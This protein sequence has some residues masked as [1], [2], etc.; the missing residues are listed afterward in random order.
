MF[1]E[2]SCTD[3]EIFIVIYGSEE[4]GKQRQTS[5]LRYVWISVDKDS[6]YTCYSILSCTIGGLKTL[7]IT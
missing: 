7:I 2:E 6:D 1:N 3:V 5:M 4:L